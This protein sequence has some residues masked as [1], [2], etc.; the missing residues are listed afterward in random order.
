MWE[1][2]SFVLV[3]WHKRTRTPESVSDPYREL[4]MKSDYQP[5]IAQ[6]GVD[7]YG[8]RAGLCNLYVRCILPTR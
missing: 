7:L 6:L 8:R 5:Q 3:P 2:R 4:R 1:K